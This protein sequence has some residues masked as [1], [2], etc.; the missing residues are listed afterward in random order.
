MWSLMT[1]NILYHIAF[2]PTGEFILSDKN[3][4][5]V[6]S[7][8]HLRYV[9]SVIYEIST[10]DK[11]IKTYDSSTTDINYKIKYYFNNLKPGEKLLSYSSSAY[12][13][14]TD[15][16]VIFHCDNSTTL[17]KS[18]FH[19]DDINELRLN[20]DS[21]YLV[22]NDNDSLYL[23]IHKEYFEV[24]NIYF[25]IIGNENLILMSRTSEYKWAANKI[26]RYKPYDANKLKISNSF[27]RR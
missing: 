10:C 2:S 27:K 13:D 25:L 3:N 7:S 9:N 4:Y 12:L 19:N 5:S 14:I 20:N 16:D 18:C 21:L 22:C 1:A 8:E 15:N 23:L 24:H 11:H 6:L 26:I 17:V